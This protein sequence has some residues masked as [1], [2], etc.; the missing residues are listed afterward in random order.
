MNFI[1]YFIPIVFLL[2][3]FVM[4]SYHY[5]KRID[6]LEEKLFISEFKH[7]DT[8]DLTKEELINFIDH[9]LLCDG[10]LWYSYDDGPQIKPASDTKDIAKFLVHSLESVNALKKYQP[11]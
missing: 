7:Y 2:V 6:E 3:L 10:V 4:D 8:S 11:E 9:A 1:T 5:Q